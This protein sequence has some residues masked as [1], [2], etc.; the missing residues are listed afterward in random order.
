ML[1][2]Y[3]TLIDTDVD[4]HK[5]V[6]L[7]EQYRHL[8]FYIAH[9]ILKDNQLSEDA[10]QEAFIRI[11]K[12]F[13]KIGDINCPQTRNYVVIITRNAAITMSHHKSDCI[14]MGTYEDS[15]PIYEDVFDT[16]S[17]K[18]IAKCIL[19]MPDIYRDMLYLHYIYGYTFNEISSLLGIS[20]NT[21]KKRAQ[22]AR[23]ILKKMIGEEGVL[24]HE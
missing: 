17:N 4:K 8:M 19:K 15:L 9:E 1:D 21:A 5:F 22:R 14:D 23:S 3:L 20:T 18:I 12:N 2:L 7:Y 6:A 16:V 10:V 24:I 11:A 13:Y